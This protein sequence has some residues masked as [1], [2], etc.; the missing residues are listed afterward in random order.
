MQIKLSNKEIDKINIDEILPF[1]ADNG[2][3]KGFMFKSGEHHYRLLVYLSNLF[4]NSFFCDIGTF[5]GSSALALAVNSSNNV[6]SFGIE[7][8]VNPISETI[9][10]LPQPIAFTRP[11]NIDFITTNNFLKYSD[12]ILDS[13][14]IFLD[15]D[16]AGEKE[17]ELYEFLLEMGYKGLMILD[18][19]HIY[20]VFNG[21]NKEQLKGMEDFWNSIKDK[22]GVYDISKWGHGETGTGLISFDNSFE[23]II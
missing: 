11:P 8:R 20:K 19:I 23:L 7:E 15:I 1:L 5:K 3:R 10:Y 6:Y 22:K 17:E 18:D 14:L 13:D 4:N 21:P 2:E 9:K 16:H 12:I